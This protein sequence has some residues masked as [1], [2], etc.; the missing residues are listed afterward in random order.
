MEDVNAGI[1]WVLSRIRHYGG[2]PKRVYLVG[3]SCGAQLSMMTLLT[4]VSCWALSAH[5]N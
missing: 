1:A 3:Q 5:H 2:D 4:Q